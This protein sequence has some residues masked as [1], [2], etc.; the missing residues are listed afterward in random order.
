MAQ[1]KSKGA[2][3]DGEGL[4]KIAFD[5]FIMS[6]E[7]WH[8]GNNPLIVMI[9]E[10]TGEKYARAIGIKGLGDTSLGEVDWLVKD[11]VGELRAWGYTGREDQRIIM[12]CDGER[13]TRKIR[14]AP[15][16][17]LGSQV[18]PEDPPK[19]EKQ[20]NGMVEEAGK[21][22]REFTRLFKDQIEQ[23]CEITLTLSSSGR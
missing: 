6:E 23:E 9:D 20:A 15:S 14:T 17:V 18:I 21:T 22:V 16:K 3:V 8:A 5:Y 4:P 13:S 7:D 10:A 1:Q 2:K 19:G 12:K 11:I